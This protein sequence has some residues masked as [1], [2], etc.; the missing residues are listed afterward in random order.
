MEQ[1]CHLLE[2]LTWMVGS[3]ALL[4][5]WAGAAAV[6]A[7]RP[8][9]FPLAVRHALEQEDWPV[10]LQALAGD[11]LT[12]NTLRLVVVRALFESGRLPEE[13]FSWI[14]RSGPELLSTSELKQ[15]A[16]AAHLAETLLQLGCLNAAERLAFDSLEMEG[17]NP[18]ALRTLARLHLVRGLTNAAGIFLNRLEA[19][20]EHQSWVDRFRAGLGT[21]ASVMPDPTITRIRENLL[22]GDRIA[23]GLTTERLLQLALESNPRNV[24]AFEYLLAHQLLQ[25]RLLFA[26]RTL[27]KSPRSHDGPLP[28]HY[29]EAVVLHRSLY[30]GISVAGLLERV[31]P[32]VLAC[33][34]DFHKVMA[35][36]AGELERVQPEAGRDFGNT[37]WY[38][39]FFGFLEPTSLSPG[40]ETPG[41]HE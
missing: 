16:G 12:N 41:T 29:A 40:P 19:Y 17:E 15:Y 18:S 1:R 23:A 6:V 30:P 4:A 36:A 9:S 37:Y 8:T 14:H 2:R 21:D 26:V 39:Y 33:F 22:G 3:W 10:L 11:P 5:G 31:P 13:Q 34:Q 28:R 38:Y 35:R 24:M 32:A 27:A 20:P 7:E 25:R